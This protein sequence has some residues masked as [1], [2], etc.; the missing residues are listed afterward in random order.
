MWI[1]RNKIAQI[2]DTKAVNIRKTTKNDKEI[3]VQF[4][5][6][7]KTKIVKLE[8]YNK[9]RQTSSNNSQI[10][11]KKQI[12]IILMVIG[13]FITIYGY[14]MDTSVSTGLGSRVTNLSLVNKQNNKIQIGGIA[15]ISGIILYALDR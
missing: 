11:T 7:P 5:D 9:Y 4:W 8:E 10:S 3:V 1:D 6:S 14:A 12:A 13:G 15:F 2:L